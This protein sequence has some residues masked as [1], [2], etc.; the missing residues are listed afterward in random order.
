VRGKIEKGLRE[1]KA[2]EIA[3]QNANALLDQLK[4]ENNLAKL[5]RENK[6]R[7][8][9]TGWFARNAQQ[10][11]KVGELQGLTAGTLAVSARKPIPERIFTQG[12][13][14]FLF[15]FK[16]SQNADM[17]QFEKEKSNLMQQARA[18]ARQR[19]LLNFKNE[20]KAKAKIEVHSGPLEE[21]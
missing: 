13:A 14:A 20:L 21:I 1:S 8:E 12:D 16:D 2:Y 6:L 15:A 4:K 11:P 3:V 7:L 10:L 5:A 9:E 19:V 17:A 18:E